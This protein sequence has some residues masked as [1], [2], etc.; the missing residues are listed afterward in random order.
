M[1]AR[2]GFYVRPFPALGSVDRLILA[3][4]V[5]G[6]KSVLATFRAQGA[7]VQPIH[8][9]RFDNDDF[10]DFESVVRTFLAG[11]DSSGDIEGAGFGVAA[12]ITG[13]RVR[14]TN[15]AW[16]IDADRLAEVLGGVRVSLL[17][18]LE[19]MA[20]GIATLE[21]DDVVTL[22]DGT[23]RP[24]NA[25]LIAAGTGLGQAQL[26][27]DGE[28]HHPSASEGGHADFGP[29]NPLEAELLAYLWNEHEHVSYERLVSGSGL[30]RIYRFLRDGGRGEDPDELVREIDA[31][32]DPS[33]V[34]SEAAQDGRSELCERALGL[35][36]E[37]YGA[38]AGNLALKNLALGGLYIGGGIAPKILP[39]LQDGRFIEAFRAKGRYRP[40]MAEI[41]VNV[42][43]NPHT[44]LRGAARY[45]AERTV[46]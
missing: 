33:I 30:H 13:R 2:E 37:I 29:R 32:E 4:D 16:T 10:S 23:P 31:A 39:H 3:G 20:H 5:G 27:W 43:L 19:A 1:G 8:H 26:F 9:R 42:V 15:R 34:I 11:A 40:L 22:Q 25:A 38:E 6:T 14:M 12:P 21:D 17:N 36:V 7:S 45:A 24:G 44:A 41:P 18:D 46:D 28:R 35:F